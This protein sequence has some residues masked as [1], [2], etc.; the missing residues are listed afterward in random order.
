MGSP[1][2]D[3]TILISDGKYLIHGNIHVEPSKGRVYERPAFCRNVRTQEA[4]LI[5]TSTC[6][7]SLPSNTSWVPPRNTL[8]YRG[9][10]ARPQ[11]TATTTSTVLDTRNGGPKCRSSRFGGADWVQIVQIHE[12]KFAKERDI[13][14]GRNRVELSRFAWQ[15]IRR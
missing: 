4:K 12:R 14:S 8:E 2:P 5:R 11:H 15:K 10:N 9:N 1:S 7:V 3:V 13:K 6:V